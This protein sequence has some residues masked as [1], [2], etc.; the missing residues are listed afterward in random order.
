MRTS[1]AKAVKKSLIT[2][3]ATANPYITL[4]P[5]LRKIYLD[6][7]GNPIFGDELGTRGNAVGR[8]QT[9]NQIVSINTR[10]REHR[11][12]IKESA[13][14]D[15]EGFNYG[16]FRWEERQCRNVDKLV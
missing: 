14:V 7:E 15:P 16:E 11:D 9:T 2:R 3:H 13:I 4:T 8:E 10:R 6:E 12:K 1:V 5:E